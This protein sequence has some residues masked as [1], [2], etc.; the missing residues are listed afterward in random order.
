VK[1]LPLK[2]ERARLRYH[3]IPGTGVPLIFIHG[4][5]CA[6][7]CDYPEVASSP[8]LAG[9]RALLIDLLG[10]GFSDRPA[11]FGY[12][13]DDHARLL[14]EGIVGLGF[15]TVHLFGHS[16]GGAITIATLL[17]ARVQGLVL[18]EPN[19]DAGGGVYSRR[20]ASLPE[21]DYVASGHDR[22]VRASRTNGDDMWAAALAL[23]SPL[24]V[25]R[26]AMSLVSGVTPSW[27]EQLRLLP[28]PKTIII[29]EK[30]RPDTDAAGFARDGV[31]VE[32]VPQAGHG[33]AWENPAGLAHAI[34]RA[35]TD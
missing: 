16:M 23:S 20:I 22:L 5:G 10:F 27:R 32:I 21:A 25:H 12:T 18:G 30:T 9:H 31:L 8:A 35:L 7:S 17:G 28:S 11:D 19:L 6:S 13:T 14:A 26:G 3:D 15:E 29:G 4:L 24:A 33:M 1:S 34:N 2:T